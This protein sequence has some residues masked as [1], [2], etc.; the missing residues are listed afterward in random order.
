VNASTL[1]LNSL[2]LLS[3]LPLAF[4]TAGSDR[5]AASTVAK[6]QCHVSAVLRDGRRLAA[7]AVTGRGNF[8]MTAGAVTAKAE[9]LLARR[10]N[11]EKPTGVLTVE[12]V[13]DLSELT[14]GLQRR[15]IRITE[16]H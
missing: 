11:G 6:P 12:D 7:T 10:D 4:F 5:R 15:G 14:P 9:V 3:K 1:A 13:F 2:G 8:A 16:M